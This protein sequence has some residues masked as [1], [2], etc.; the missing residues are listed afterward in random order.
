[1]FQREGYFY[2]FNSN[3]DHHHLIYSVLKAT[4]KKE[5]PKLYKYCDYKKFN[6]TAFQTDPQNK[7]EEGPTVYQNFEEIFVRVLDAQ[8]QRKT[9][10]LCGNN[11]P[12]VDKNLSKAIIKNSPLK[13]KAS[14]IKQQEEITKKYKK[15]SN[16]VIKLNRGMKLQYLNSLKTL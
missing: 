16:L 10:V 5:E 3:R 12:Y 13:R 6:S 9:K 4:F 2:R 11:R 15:Q 1:M 8:A 7:L 14:Q